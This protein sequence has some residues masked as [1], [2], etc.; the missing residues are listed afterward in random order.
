[1]VEQ[2]WTAI[3]VIASVLLEQETVSYGDI[4]R[5]LNERCPDSTLGKKS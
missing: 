1:M 2:N 5:I 4:I 3:D